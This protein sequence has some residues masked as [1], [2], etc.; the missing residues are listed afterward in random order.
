M[1][2]KGG[3]GG[4][5]DSFKWIKHNKEQICTKDRDYKYNLEVASFFFQPCT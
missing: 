4:V 3:G 5:D 2:G 1:G